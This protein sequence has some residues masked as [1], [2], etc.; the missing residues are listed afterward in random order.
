VRPCG[1]R[2]R[3][4][5]LQSLRRRADGRERGHLTCGRF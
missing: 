2:R 4:A 5:S 3:C 1:A